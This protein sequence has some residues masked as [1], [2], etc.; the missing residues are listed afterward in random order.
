MKFI[1]QISVVKKVL[2]TEKLLLIIQLHTREG[3]EKGGL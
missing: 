1:G 3:A 2:K